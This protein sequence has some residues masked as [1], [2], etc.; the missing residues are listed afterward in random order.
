MHR[1][2]HLT[3]SVQIFVGHYEMRATH[4]IQILGHRSVIF[5]LEL[6]NCRNTYNF[7]LLQ[8]PDM[9]IGIRRLRTFAIV[10]CYNNETRR[11]EN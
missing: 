3:D 10:K 2:S 6:N 11:F 8:R 5:N 7:R 4:N 1:K 9:I